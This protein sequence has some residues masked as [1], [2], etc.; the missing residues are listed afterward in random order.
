[1]TA[2][3]EIVGSDEY[4][5]IDLPEPGGD[6]VERFVEVQSYW[7]NLPT[8]WGHQRVQIEVLVEPETATYWSTIESAG[9]SAAGPTP[10]AAAVAAMRAAMALL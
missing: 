7:T 2:T 9:V 5:V 3:I 8:S 4:F 1:M 10:A 6:H